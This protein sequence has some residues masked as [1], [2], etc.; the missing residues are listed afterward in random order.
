MA[1][2]RTEH[3]IEGHTHLM[4][5]HHQAWTTACSF[6]D[7]R[8]VSHNDLGKIIIPISFG[9]VYKRAQ[10]LRQTAI[11]AFYNAI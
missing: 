11:K 3:Y 7:R 4:A 6:M 10:H 2:G 1:W 9:V 5:I 8:V